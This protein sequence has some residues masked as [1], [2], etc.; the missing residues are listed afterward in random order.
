[1]HS[2][3]AKMAPQLAPQDLASQLLQEEMA[4]LHALMA[5]QE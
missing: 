4:A 5:W 1:M 2:I 3:S